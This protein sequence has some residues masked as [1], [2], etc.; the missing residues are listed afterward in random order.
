MTRRP[1]PTLMVLRPLVEG[2]RVGVGLGACN[3]ALC[4]LPRPPIGCN[5]PGVVLFEPRCRWKQPRPQAEIQWLRSGGAR[6]TLGQK[7]SARFHDK[8]GTPTRKPRHSSTPAYAYIQNAHSQ[9]YVRADDRS[10]RRESHRRLLQF[11]R[12]TLPTGARPP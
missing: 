1:L 12:E 8:S 5:L 11:N 6:V 4:R 7:K 10:P 2:R 9:R 3:A